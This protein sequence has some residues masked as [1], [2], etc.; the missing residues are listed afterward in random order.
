MSDVPQVPDDRTLALAFYLLV[1]VSYSMDGAPLD[2]VN[3]I[4]PEVIDTIEESPTLGDVVRFG[5]L[6]FADDARTVL[7]LGDLR[8]VRA[9]PQFTARGGTSYAAAFRRLRHDIGHDLARL[10]GEGFQVYRPAVFFVTDG[11]PTDAVPEV[12]AAFAE[13]TDPGFR[14]RPNI[15]PFGVTPELPGDS[16]E[17]WVHPKPGTG[18]K[19]MRSYVYG[20]AGDAATA[21]RQIADVLISSIVASA[22]SVNDAGA[23]GGFVPPDD[24]DL[25]DWI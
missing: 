17:P 19:P 12:R 6:D 21:I 10:R 14:G 8:D 24:D 3:R 11:A 2:A 5:A 9:I 4:L 22:N 7:P 13:L 20:G 18:G 23:A 1:D 25:G 15:I 16:L